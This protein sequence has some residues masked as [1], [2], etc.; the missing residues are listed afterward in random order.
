MNPAM[1]RM[2]PWVGY[3]LY[4]LLS[5]VVM[6]YVVFPTTRIK[7]LIEDSVAATGQMTLA[8]GRLRTTPLLGLKAADLVLTI[9]RA[10]ELPIGGSDDGATKA[11]APH[12]YRIERATFR[13][14]L[15]AALSGGTDLSF[16]LDA[17]N[18]HLSGSYAQ[19]KKAGLALVLRLDG[20]SVAKISHLQLGPP[21]G[22]SLS[23]RI[24]LAMPPKRIDQSDG[25]IQLECVGCTLGDGKAKLKVK[26]NAFMAAGLTL[27]KIDLGTLKLAATLTKGAAQFD[28]IS[29]RSPD[30]ELAAE[31]GLTL[32]KPLAYS[33]TRSYVRFKLSP[34]LKTRSPA[35]GALEMAYASGKRSDGFYGILIEGVVKAPKAVP[36]ALGL[37][38]KHTRGAGVGSR[39]GASPSRRGIGRSSR[40]RR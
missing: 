19:S 12:R 24:A 25:A 14:G 26:G 18:G 20:L 13:S 28:D 38:T 32:R 6:A 21:L 1:K 40:R 15:W 10:P 17:L 7:A 2:L 29:A 11:A 27:P 39:L 5:L 4:G 34:T 22:G 23:G 9:D 31:G 16:D 8:I 33:V 35:A 3:P 30:V 36:S 37:G